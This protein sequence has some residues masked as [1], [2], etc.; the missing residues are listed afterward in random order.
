MLYVTTRNNRDAFTAQRALRENR[1]PDGG[2]YLPLRM[3]KFSAEEINTLA[4]KSFGQNVADVLNLLFKL[5]LT[6]WDVD[7]CIGRYPARL[8]TLRHRIL[9]G[10]TWHNPQWN[11]ERVVNNLVS[12]LCDE[13]TVPGDW[14]KIAVRVA[15][16]FGIFGELKHDGIN[17]A[18]ISVVSGDFSAP[19]SAWYARQWGL[20]I[21][22]IICCCNENNSLWDLICHGQ[23]RTDGLSIATNTPEADVVIPE[24]L[25][26][27]I[28]EC[29]GIVEVQRYLQCCREGKP[30][31]PNDGILAK[32]RKGMFVSVV[33]SSRLESTIPGVYR[34]S[35]YLMS[36]STALAYAG[37]LDYRAKTGETRCAVVLTEKSPQC[38]ADLVAQMLGITTGELREKL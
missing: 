15:V 3:P 2:M 25:E 9:M 18:D 36:A 11:Y 21:D 38:D 30:Y 34:T 23:M 33:S 27:L 17:S 14:V 8:V 37:L 4:E 31:A 1:A 24:D 12:H 22:N 6:S 28:Y 32:L 26:R 20:P 35:S 16:L 10:E 7:F 13:M 29:G 19:I 5:K